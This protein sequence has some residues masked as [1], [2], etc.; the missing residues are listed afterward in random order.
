[1]RDRDTV[2]RA[3]NR[4]YPGGGYNLAQTSDDVVI[5]AWDRDEPKPDIDVLI[6]RYNADPDA[7]AESIRP[8]VNE[9]ARRRIALLTLGNEQRNQRRAARVLY[10]R[11]QVGIGNSLPEP[12]AT[13]ES[14]MVA[15]DDAIEQIVERS[16]MIRTLSD[17]K[18]WQAEQ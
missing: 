7:V 13:W 4:F 11:M 9:E 6:A 12:Y 1:M 14:Q 17:L 18:Q 15:L 2:E 8:L 16:N 5:D 3:L 10:E